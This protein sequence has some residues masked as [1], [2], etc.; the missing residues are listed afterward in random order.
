LKHCGLQE[1][2]ATASTSEWSWLA[3]CNVDAPNEGDA[4]TQKCTV[5]GIGAEDASTDNSLI[6]AQKDKLDEANTVAGSLAKALKDAD[7]TDADFT[8]PLSTRLTNFENW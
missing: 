4:S 7:Y 6:K 8:S 1:S 2:V 5:L 3:N